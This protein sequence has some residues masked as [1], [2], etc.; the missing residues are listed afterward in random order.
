MNIPLDS[1]AECKF[2]SKKAKY[3]FTGEL[4][5][6]R[7]ARNDIE[8]KEA[9]LNKDAVNKFLGVS[10]RFLDDFVSR[11]LGL[12]LSEKLEELDELRWEEMIEAG[13][14]EIPEQ[15]SYQT[16]S[17]AFLLYI[18]HMSDRGIPLHPKERVDHS[19]FTCEVCGEEAVVLPDPR[20]YSTITYC[21]NCRAK[22][23]G[24]ACARCEQIYIE[25]LG[26]WEK[27]DIPPEHP[28]LKSLLNSGEDDMSFCQMCQGWIADQ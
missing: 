17:L 25:Y 7:Q 6:L 19:F 27:G 20:S 28:D 2:N 1:Y 5:E 4:E 22:Y 13:I 10:F 16:L 23:E 11:E 14:E 8:H 26:E 21:Y 24:H 15:D 12:S 3:Q 9:S 18:K